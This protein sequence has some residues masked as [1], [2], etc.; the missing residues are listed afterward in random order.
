MERKVVEVT[1]PNNTV[2]LVSAVDADGDVPG[3]TKT[4]ALGGFDLA[5]VGR[6]LEGLAEAIKGSMAKAAP[7]RVTVELGLELVVKSG[8]LTGLLVEGGGTGSLQVT[9]EWDRGDGTS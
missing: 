4:S 1:L 5:E 3:A 9:M 8:K 2:A 6:T 7:D